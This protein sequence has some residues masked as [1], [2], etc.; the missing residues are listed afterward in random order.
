M[1]DLEIGLLPNETMT[2]KERKSVN[3]VDKLGRMICSVP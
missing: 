1:Y 3:D 2:A